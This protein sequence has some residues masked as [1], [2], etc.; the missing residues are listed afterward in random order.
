MRSAL[1]KLEAPAKEL[2]TYHSML[3]VKKKKES[4]KYGAF[5]DELVTQIEALQKFQL[6]L[7]VWC[8]EVE[9]IQSDEADDDMMRDLLANGNVFKDAAEAHLNGVK[10]GCTKYKGL[11][12]IVK[13]K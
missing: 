9:E 11:L 12:S 1:K 5:C 7:C 4:A 6:D 3:L 8:C 2:G 13:E 10:G